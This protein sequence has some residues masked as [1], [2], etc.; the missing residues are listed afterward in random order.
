MILDAHAHQFMYENFAEI[1][2]ENLEKDV[3][4]ILEN[5]LNPET[6]R[7]VLDLAKK[8]EIVYPA[9]GL[10]PTDVVKMSLEEINSELEFMEKN[11]RE[12]TAIGEVGL[13][14]YWVKDPNLQALQKK[15]FEQ[16]LSL[17]ERKQK[18]IIIHSRQAE[19]EVLEMLESF[20]VTAIL[21][22]F[23]KPKL[24]KHAIDLGVYISIPA[25]LV[26]DKGL[27]KICEETP[28]ELLLTETDSP[29]LDPVERRNNKSWKISYALPKICELKKISLDDL[30][31]TLL[32]NFCRVFDLNARDLLERL[33]A[34]QSS[35][36][37]GK[38]FPGKS[39]T[40]S[41][42]GREY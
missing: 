19:R 11:I 9:L 22:S 3:I 20:R 15:V 10:H 26:R 33:S 2:Q 28:L 23:W 8:H 4:F 36:S 25:F 38:T 39:N 14:F 41:S 37:S 16:I 34:S 12:I 21:H 40:K 32:K 5:G 27:Q 31:E 18:S 17:A 1:I 24:I 13:D 6:N 30:K 42:A 29:F 7:L 35:G